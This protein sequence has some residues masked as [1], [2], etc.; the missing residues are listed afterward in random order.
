MLA[1]IQLQFKGFRVTQN[2]I[3][4]GDNG[5][6]NP[7]RVSISIT[8]LDLN[9]FTDISVTAGSDTRTLLLNPEN[10]VV[11]SPTVLALYFYDTTETRGGHWSIFG[12]NA[13]NPFGV[14]ITNA[15]KGNLSTYRI[16]G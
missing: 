2:I 14:N 5:R 12:F 9:G 11:E 7:V 10:V 15:C 8:N 16:C 6:N 3:F 4:K 13:T 1:L